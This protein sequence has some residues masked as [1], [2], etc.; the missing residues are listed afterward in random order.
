MRTS[1]T[2]KE[3]ETVQRLET[4]DLDLVF[5]A[6]LVLDEKLGDVLALITLQLN[7]LA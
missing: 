5:V 4:V 2:S 6:D 1:N 7:N 3:I